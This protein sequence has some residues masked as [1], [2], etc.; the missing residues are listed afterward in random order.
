MVHQK[1]QKKQEEPKK[2]E[3]GTIA[4]PI[5][6]LR[7]K[8]KISDKFREELAG[9]DAQQPPRPGEFDPRREQRAGPT[10]GA[11]TT[12]LFP[13]ILKAQE[14]FNKGKAQPVE[15]PTTG[16]SGA[17]EPD[18]AF[19][20][21][22]GN[23]TAFLIDG[24]FLPF[25]NDAEA[26]AFLQRRQA[27]LATPEGVL[28]AG[29]ASGVRRG[30]ELAGTVGQF[31]EEQ[32]AQIEGALPTD[33]TNRQ[34]FLSGLRGS[35]G[36]GIS[37]AITGATTLGA[38]G[39]I[40]GGPGGAIIGGGIGAIGGFTVGGARGYLEAYENNIQSQ[41]AGEIGASGIV[42]RDN[43]RQMRQA[44][45]NM[46]S[47][48]GN[49]IQNR[50]SFNQALVNI[51]AEHSKIFQ[52]TNSDLNLFLSQDGTQT[53]Q[54]YTDFFNPNGMKDFLINE[55]QTAL[56]NPTNEARSLELLNQIDMEGFE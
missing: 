2:E 31:T 53:L 6:D 51:E 33:F 48:K 50:D 3:R 38:A 47:N 7:K 18:R 32:I 11:I 22:Q 14:Q 27:K 16:G 49:M 24:K 40:A 56:T 25:G 29:E 44:S 13:D 4:P 23:I 10:A 30:R 34:T 1:K 37:G 12:T 26:R 20:D 19:R 15:D 39:A 43:M 21:E 52:E 28:E 55:F 35:V 41:A 36:G 9:V 46:W 45:A 17:E 42:L 54:K 8:I 5:P